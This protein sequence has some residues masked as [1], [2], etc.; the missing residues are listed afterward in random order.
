M[1]C[2]SDDSRHELIR[3]ARDGDARRVLRLL[4]GW[5]PEYLCAGQADLVFDALS[6]VEPEVL[7]E[8]PDV[9]LLA[10][11]LGRL[12]HGSVPDPGAVAERRYRDLAFSDHAKGWLQ[13]NLLAVLRARRRGDLGHA[14]R[15]ILQGRPV[16][17]RTRWDMGSTAIA[18]LPIWFCSAGATALLAGD[19]A[20]SRELLR[21]ARLTRER[22]PVVAGDVF[23]RVDQE[24]AESLALLHAL[25]GDL[26]QAE[27]ERRRHETG[28]MTAM[29]RI[30]DELIDLDQGN[31][32]P[33]VA[34]EAVGD[35]LGLVGVDVP[36]WP[37]ELF[38]Q[39]Q[40]SLS[41]GALA[42]ARDVLDQ[43]LMAPASPLERHTFGRTIVRMAQIDVA[44]A[45][46][47]GDEARTLLGSV[48]PDWLIGRRARLELL[49]DR[50]ADAIVSATA[51]LWGSQSG[52]RERVELQT[53]KAVAQWRTQDVDGAR[54][55]IAGAITA[56]RP[57]RHLRPFSLLGRH[58]LEQLAREVQELD[59]ILQAID[60][61]GLR[62]IFGDNATMTR[63]TDR[64]RAVL[65]AVAAGGSTLDVAQRLHVSTNTVKSQLRTTYLKLGV[66]T[67]ADAVARAVDIGLLEPRGAEAG[68]R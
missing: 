1:A 39:V 55:S 22:L 28:P 8:H 49:V 30:A 12:P 62:Q 6:V 7:R 3:A 20:L 41:N 35:G 50:P 58:E 34:T 4:R 19:L 14:R 57:H 15:L 24:I 42:S 59:P 66:R 26:R 36:V 16:A 56:A 44:L 11:M 45:G 46:G 63:L 54:D 64:E 5:W 17:D 68:C 40:R 2:W 61:R 52:P 32:G 53:L 9:G 23:A 47:D 18:V 65:E 13:A 43:A 31:P 51:A 33:R 27:F 21:L 38:I 48:P 25:R 29:G 60:E 10:E 37:F 67:R